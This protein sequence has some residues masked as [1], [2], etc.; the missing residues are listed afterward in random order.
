MKLFY[1]ESFVRRH[2]GP[3]EKQIGRM[4]SL[5]CFK[6][7]DDMV[8]HVVPEKILSSFSCKKNEALSER[9][10]KDYVSLLASM[11]HIYRSYIG[12]G[13]Y[14]TITPS[15]LQRN[16]LENP[17]WYTAYTPY[18]AEIS[19]GRLEALINFQNMVCDLTGMEIAN[20]S[21]LDEATAASEAMSLCYSLKSNQDGSL[22]F[23]DKNIFPATRS[24]L[25]TRAESLGIK[26]VEGDINKLDHKSRAGCF[27]VF[28][29]Y[30]SKSG[31]LR[32]QAK[33]K[34]KLIVSSDLLSLTL[35]EPPGEWGADVVVGSTQRLGVPMGYGGPHAAYLATK[36]IYK[37][38]LPGRLVGVSK[39]VYERTAYRL[40]LQTREQHIRREKATSNICTA[41]VL[42][43]VMASCYA[44]Y[45]GPK[46]LKAIASQIHEKTKLLVS[47]LLKQ[48][49]KIPQDTYFDTF[50]IFMA[51]DQ[52]D[53]VKKRAEYERVNLFYSLDRI[54]LSLDETVTKKDI[55]DL[56]FIFT[57]SRQ[58]LPEDLKVDLSY[59]PLCFK[60]KSEFLTHKIFNSYHSE[61]E[62]MRYLHSLAK[63]DL[64]LNQSMIPLGSC[65]MK[66]NSA[67]EMEAITDI[68][69]SNLHPFVPHYQAKG[70]EV[71]MRELED[72]L[73]KLTGFSAF[74]FQPNAGS[75]GE[76]AGLLAIRQY[77]KSR[78]DEKRNI[79]L[80]P[81]SAH[82]T[83][84]SSAVLAG[85]EVIPV[86]CDEK[87]NI[88]LENLKLK[89]KKY[90]ERISC[91]M[92]TYPSTH[93]VFEES[94]KEICAWVHEYGGQVYMDGANFNAIVGLCR[95]LDLGCDVAHLNLHK[96]FCIPHG[97]G[98]PGVG[99]IGI[100]EHL[101]NYLP[102]HDVVDLGFKGKPVS[103]APWGSASILLISWS[104]CRMMGFEGLKKA[105]QVAILNANYLRH[106]L[107]DHYEVL[108]TGQGGFV[109]HECILDFRSFQLKHDITVDDIAKRL[110]DYGFHAPTQSWPLQ[111]T[112]MIEPTESETKGELD[113]FCEALIAIREEIREIETKKIKKE[114][115]VLAKAP[116]TIEDLMQKNWD[117]AYSK[118]KAFYPL[119]W[120]KD[121]KFLIP[122][123]RIDNVYGDRN[124][125][126]TC[127]PLE[128]YT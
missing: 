69:W 14:G 95:L 3:D 79:C 38:R 94:V 89:L 114:D 65:T 20:S 26:C 6:S 104:Y 123:N 67:T 82:G 27:A 24:I 111:G 48:G 15:V 13:Y 96:T 44:V 117:R 112:L 29:Q 9:G 88:D 121:K 39:D 91:F 116:H 43:A 53:E 12:H 72:I 2:I 124:L 33:G 127:V 100:A 50:E 125:F 37:R 34:S 17:S 73:K 46:G 41:Q 126:C 87:G 40:A 101:K 30:P 56:I 21:L 113:R 102:S 92:I 19:Q 107:K 71:M 70:Y 75:Q 84:P 52:I 105:T 36:K 122:V 59:E 22:F 68:R 11:N 5:L 51:Q 80:I 77:H 42:L 23:I 18:Q 63:K 58:N 83:N 119:P 90:K 98:G 76:Y 128:E 49:L 109:A 1:E 61:T 64:A 103:Q 81:T 60:R 35:L 4:L 47:E 108:F 86:A 93:G 28:V 16:I 115:S 10:L 32:K 110:M 7:L 118:N 78:G 74:S 55:E 106:R 62:M 99:P 97:G 45:H 31:I 57:G 66:L 120:L 25:L 54:R 85:M 8:S